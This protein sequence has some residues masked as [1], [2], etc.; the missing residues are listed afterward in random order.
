MVEEDKSDEDQ[1][2]E[3]FESTMGD[4]ILNEKKLEFNFEVSDNVKIP[5]APK[6]KITLKAGVDEIIE[7][8]KILSLRSNKGSILNPQVVKISEKKNIMTSSTNLVMYHKAIANLT[9]QHN[10]V[11][12]VGD[13]VIDWD[14][15]INKLETRF[16]TT[17][18]VAMAFLPEQM[19]WVC[20][21][22]PK[23][24][25]SITSM[26]YGKTVTWKESEF[27]EI[28]E[29]GILK[30]FEAYN[31]QLFSW[32]KIKVSQL[33]N[34]VKVCDS[35]GQSHIPLILNSSG[36]LEVNLKGSTDISK[37]EEFKDSIKIDKFHLEEDRVSSNFREGIKEYLNAVPSDETV[38]IY[39]GNDTPLVAC[40]DGKRSGIRFSSKTLI[41]PYSLK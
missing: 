36:E 21:R 12:G 16:N 10:V 24:T 3:L 25:T 14:V 17:D 8:S 9:N 26:P 33:S 29:K 19:K 38:Q 18:H 11:D 15:F 13:L 31:Q 4:D 40:L 35:F 30:G 28:K 41:Q 27:K 20:L 1:I 6:N 32:M 34:V 22:H 23:T 2:K 7:L 39:W 5:I 37:G